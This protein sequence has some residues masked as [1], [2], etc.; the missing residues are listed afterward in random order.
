MRGPDVRE[1][2]GH[3]GGGRKEESRTAVE[4]GFVLQRVWAGAGRAIQSPHD[5]ARKRG[6]EPHQLPNGS[7]ANKDWR[8][9]VEKE[10]AAVVEGIVS[11]IHPRRLALT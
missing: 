3:G 7:H 8:D 10:K 1:N 5:R 2:R 4:G 6:P 9:A 11:E